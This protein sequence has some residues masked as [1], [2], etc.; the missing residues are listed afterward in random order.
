M[1]VARVGLGKVLVTVH[2]TSDPVCR[3]GIA[4]TSLSTKVDVV[5]IWNIT[6]CGVYPGVFAVD[7]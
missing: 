4:R 5:N 1:V 2:P 3:K 7:G 6:N